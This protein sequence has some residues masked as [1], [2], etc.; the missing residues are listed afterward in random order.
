MKLITRDT[1]Y[2][3]RALAFIAGKKGKIVSA[4][5]LVAEL[6][7]PRP[8][9]RKILQVL[10][11]KGTLKSFKGKGGGFSLGLS[12][13]KIYLVDLIETFQGPLKLN[14]CFFKKMLCPNRKNCALR[15]K[16]GN[17]ESRVVSEL[18]TISLASLLK[19]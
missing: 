11:K 3:V 9:L 17:I 4:A 10:N 19:G 18:K 7:M 13:S 6:G 1:D 8:F 12:S 14:E 5:E 16:I 2:A 15:R